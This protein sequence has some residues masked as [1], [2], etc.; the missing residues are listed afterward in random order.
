ML[1]RRLGFA[2]GLGAALFLLMVSMC[3]T[4]TY[5]QEKAADSSATTLDNLMA[6]YKGESNAQARY[7]AF[8]KKANEEG[9]DIAASLFRAVALAERVHYER[10]AG[11]IKKLGGTLNAAVEIPVVKSTPENL[12]A[13]FEGETYEKD[14]MYPAFLIQAQKEE[15]KDAIDAFEDTIAAEGVHADLYARMSSNLVLSRGLSKDFLVCPV[16][17]NVVDVITTE[18]CPICSTETRKFKMVR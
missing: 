4:N 14:V 7:L 8:A 15:M 1:I 10:Y 17:G 3:L 16:C 18:L 2:A 11:I 5:A 6:A 13:A 9:Y 12:K